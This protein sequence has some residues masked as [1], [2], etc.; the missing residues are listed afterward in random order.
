MYTDQKYA[1]KLGTKKNLVSLFWKH[2]L[3]YC[4][5]YLSAPDDMATNECQI[6]P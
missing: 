1:A 5:I 4:S 6:K 3:S 2:T